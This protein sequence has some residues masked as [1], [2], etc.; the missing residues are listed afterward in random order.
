MLALPFHAVPGIGSFQPSELFALPLLCLGLARLVSRGAPPG[1]AVDLGVLAWLLAVATASLI[2]LARLGR[3]DALVA[4]ELGIA[5]YLGALYLA[6]RAVSRELELERVAAAFVVSGALA[7]GLGLLGSVGNELGLQTALAFPAGTSYPYLGA[8]SRARAFTATPNMLADLAGLALLLLVAGAARLPA[9]ARTAAAVVGALGFTATLSKTALALPAAAL[10]ARRLGRPPGTT[11]RARVPA[12]AA[13]LA[14]A[15]AYAASAHFVLVRGEAERARLEAGV[16][17]SGPPFARWDLGGERWS[18]HATNY[19]FNKRAS[20]TAIERSWP[21]GIGPGRQPVLAETL[22]RE[23]LYPAH[24]WAGSPHSS[25]TGALAEM[26]LAGGLGLGAFVAALLIGTRRALRGPARPVAAAAAGF[27]AMLAIEALATDV[28]HF[29]QLAW[30][31][32]LVA[33][34]QASEPGD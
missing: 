33:T 23:G 34:A 22:R 14:C 7:A 6:V 2:S 28:M 15:V 3:L 20:L 11:R 12:L 30:V 19:F 29:R 21:Y 18:V 26:G 8:A 17:V 27:L 16:F 32:A 13:W 31:A 24:Q 10:I 4:R 1:S 25:Y 9:R 5:C